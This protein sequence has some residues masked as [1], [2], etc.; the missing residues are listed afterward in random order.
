MKYFIIF[1]LF[2]SCLRKPRTGISNDSN[3]GKSVVTTDTNGGEA[4]GGEDS[5]GEDDGG[6]D[7]AGEDNG[8]DDSGDDD[9]HDDEDPVG[10]PKT[11]ANF[12]FEVADN[13]IELALNEEVII[14][15]KIK[16]LKDFKG[17]DIDLTIED[18]PAYIE[19]KSDL[20][21]INLK[22]NESADLQISVKVNTMSE[23]FDSKKFVLLGSNGNEAMGNKMKFDLKVKPEITI[24]IINDAIPHE[25]NIKDKDICLNKHNEGLQV[26]FK[27]MTMNFG[28]N[29]NGPCIH[30]VRPLKHCDTSKRMKPGDTYLPPKVMADAGD[31]SAVF[32][33]HFASNDNIQRKLHF[34]VTAGQEATKNCTQE[35]ND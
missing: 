18:I 25:Y 9:D 13:K 2:F 21:K 23:S 28:D 5:A 12:V 16:A 7:S 34:N 35:N 29:G 20:E 8:G 15:V 11:S 32:Y 33:N 14:P 3:S 17:G 19:I 27:N 4:A 31:R 10:P 26:I 6:D 30:T 24:G 1:I 22:T